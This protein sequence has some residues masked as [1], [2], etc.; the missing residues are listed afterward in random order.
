[1]QKLKETMDSRENSSN[2]K[3]KEVAIDTLGKLVH[4]VSSFVLKSSKNELSFKPQPGKW[5]KKEI[6]GHLVDSGRNSEWTAPIH[7]EAIQSR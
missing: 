6:I 4:Q 7:F 3:R 2:E 1:L 5:S